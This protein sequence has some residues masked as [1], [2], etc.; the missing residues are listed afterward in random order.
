MPIFLATG[1]IR[2]TVVIFISLSRGRRSEGFILIAICSLAYFE[3]VHDELPSPLPQTFRLFIF[4][5]LLLNDLLLLGYLLLDSILALKFLFEGLGLLSI[6]QVLV[7]EILDGLLA[8]RE[9]VG[10]NCRVL[11]R[12]VEPELFGAVL[13]LLED[14]HDRLHA[15]WLLL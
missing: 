14:P 4:L 7:F 10:A 8:S 9:D 12:E 13:Q 6:I 11:L 1:S 5:I 3:V 15:R 2:L